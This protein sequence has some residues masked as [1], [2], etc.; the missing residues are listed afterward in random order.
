MKAQSKQIP[1]IDRRA[2]FL[3]ETLNEGKRTIDVVWSTGARVK[4]GGLWTEPFFEEL[5]M[6]KESVRLDRLN[7]G[8]P[9]LNNHNNWD[10]ND[11]IGVVENAAVSGGEGRATVRFSERENVNPIYNDVKTGIIRNISVGYKVHRFEKQEESDGELAV[12]RAVD[13]EPMELSFVAIPADAGAQVRNSENVNLCTFITRGDESMTQS[14]KQE[15]KAPE[16]KQV[17][18]VDEKKVREEA[19]AAER[20]RCQKIKEVVR[21]VKLED[22]LADQMIKDG[23]SVEK[24]RTL[25]IEKLAEKQNETETRSTNVATT[26]DENETR[27]RGAENAILNRYNSAR[28][29]LDDNGRRFRSFSLLDLAREFCEAHGISTRELSKMEVAQRAF[30]STSDFPILLAD[31]ANKSLR[32]AY[33]EAPQTHMAISR[34]VT[35][36]DFK[37]VSRVQLG[38]GPELDEVLES[39]EVTYGTVGEAKE[40][41][42]LK[43]YAKAISLTR[44]LIINDDLDALARI[45]ALFGRRAR[46][47]EADLIW[48]I[49][50]G[51]P[52]M[53]DG[54]ALF[55][56]DHGNLAASGA[57][58]SVTTIGA[59]R[60]AMRTQTGL[61]GAVVNVT[62]RQLIV[63]AALETVAE[64]FLATVI[65][66]ESDANSNPFKGSLRP[67]VEPRLDASSSTAW[68]LAA[69]PAAIDM[70]ELGR[71][72]GESGP[73]LE[74]QEGFEI[75]GMKMKV[76]I[77]I[78]VK[79]ID[80][81]GF[82]KNAGA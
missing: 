66:P 31:V 52:A 45:P 2:T 63:P 55:H 73:V 42:Q 16:T 6:K 46:E 80:Y 49:I 69:D 70:I 72:Q 30:H 60:L 29:Q 18:E 68:Y 59:G 38:D 75:E 65:Y 79:A 43:T 19:I 67:L 28:Y 32:D 17:P 51:N 44:K 1:M 81:R 23:S 54:T 76:R 15:G 7:R 62:P 74:T 25:V 37:P 57:A 78:G 5:S 4:R 47:K 8:A 21:S 40:Q 50:T 64:Q 39:G 13:W 53:A 10:L 9:L 34:E 58:I 12:Y 26:R 48:A 33:G 82:Y 3:P 22:S 24:A 14:T 35:L 56:A 20:T 27:I 36:S 71:L 11:V 61:D 77:D 41:I